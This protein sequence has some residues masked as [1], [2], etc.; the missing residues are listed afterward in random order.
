MKLTWSVSLLLPLSSLLLLPAS[1]ARAQSVPPP[2]V[3]MP[4]AT[5]FTRLVTQNFADW[6]TNGD[7]MLSPQEIDTLV[8][9]P[10]VTGDEAAAIATLKL[11]FI[12]RAK[13]GDPPLRI[14]TDFLAHYAAAPRSKAF[15]A[16][17]LRFRML[18]RRIHA[19]PA[20][21]FATASAPQLANIHQG[22]IGDCFYLAVVG[23]LVNRDSS[24]VRHMIVP[25]ADG[26]YDVTFPAGQKAHVPPITDAEV[27]LSSNPMGSGRWLPVLE[28]AF[29]TVRETL[30]GVPIPNDTT[31]VYGS[32]EAGSGGP[33]TR[34]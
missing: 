12:R 13:I 4:A 28:A 23:D 33:T 3:T 25:N 5:P 10:R 7:G 14:T 9:D 32:S 16:F 31:T 21:L 24:E 6:D 34:H 19:T 27:A 30:P 2:N 20:A 17:D 18:A 8:A 11:A 15:P 1:P 26:S 22:M 29:G